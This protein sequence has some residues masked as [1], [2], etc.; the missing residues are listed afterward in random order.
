VRT[1][2]VSL[3]TKDAMEFI[4]AKIDLTKLDALVALHAPKMKFNATTG[5]ANLGKDATVWPSVPMAL[6]SKDVVF[7]PPISSLVQEGAVSRSIYA[8]TVPLIVLTAPTSKIAFTSVQKISFGVV[9]E[10]A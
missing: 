8:V 10:Y 9:P 4:I 7:A 5:L 1:V 6:M 2:F 3:A